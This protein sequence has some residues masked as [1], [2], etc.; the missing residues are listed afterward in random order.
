MVF[1]KSIFYFIFRS[2]LLSITIFF[3]YRLLLFFLEISRISWSQ[4][5][6][7][8][9]LKSFVMGIRFDIVISGYI[10]FIPIFILLVGYIFGKQLKQLHKL[11]FYWIFILF[12][13]SFVISSA[14]IPYFQQF[15]T[16][17]SVGA[18]EW[19]DSPAFVFKMLLEEPSYFLF[20]IPFIFFEVFFY[21]QL[22]KNFEI[23]SDLSYINQKIVI[24][25]GLS[26]IV[27]ALMFLGI[28]GRI[29]KKSPI[30]IGTAYFCQD[31]FLNQL[32]LN[33]SFTLIRSYLDTFDKKNQEVQLMNDKEAVSNV[34]KYL[35]ITNNKYTSPIARKISCDS[36]ITTKPNIIIV[37]MESMSAAKMKRHG[38]KFN[39]TPFLDSLSYKSYYF[40]H[41][42]TAGEH[43]YN[44]IFSTL[45][46][47][48]ALYRQHTMKKIR[49]YHGIASVLK[50][51]GYSTIYFTTHDSQFDNVEGF[52]RANSFDRII[53]QIDYPE[54]EIKTTLG[55]PDDYMFRFSM[56][57]LNELH[58]KGKPFFST[59][60]TTSDHGPFYIPPYFH[61]KSSKIKQQIVEY[62][63]WSLRQFIT[64]ASKQDWF[65][66]TIFVFVADHGAAI[67]VQYPIA[68]NYHH[69]PLLFYAPKL[70]K[71]KLFS[72][73]GGQ[74]D[75]FPTIM[76]L[77]KQDY[78]NNTLG[79]DLINDNRPYIMINADNKVA[80]LDK[81]FLFILNKDSKKLY[82]YQTNNKSDFIDSL[83]SKAKEM[84]L[85]LKSNLQAYQYLLKKDLTKV[86]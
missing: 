8:N 46:S 2:Y 52:L 1:R 20:V 63:D 24:K 72:N 31:P 49:Q 68:L 27:L 85:Y 83:P 21:K 44:G 40:D 35:H 4:E 41:I 7:V 61:P 74:I 11:L 34:Q 62:A 16:R 80:A 28:R 67:D 5:S 33:P 15:F 69:S 48:P 82:K 29:Q 13:L 51:K 12:S 47:F 57:I 73:I 64:A 3:V 6:I 14:D 81:D 43:T 78:I 79:V 55:V 65:D 86:N 37:I 39:L 45:F 54:K 75:V 70:L 50:D 53:S 17:F 66:N 22:K 10:L 84:E 25:T 32:G 19:I 71:P 23:I 60:M 59:F 42:Y 18:F 58:Q 30:R 77:L 36:V 26:L 9:V 38:N 56:P 76:G